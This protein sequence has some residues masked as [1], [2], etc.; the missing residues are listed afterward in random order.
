MKNS[1]RRDSVIDWSIGHWI[2]EG[3][4]RRFMTRIQFTGAESTANEDIAKEMWCQLRWQH[5]MWECVLPAAACL[6]LAYGSNG[7]HYALEGGRRTHAHTTQQVEIGW[8][9]AK[10]AIHTKWNVRFFF[11]FFTS[12][13]KSIDYVVVVIASEEMSKILLCYFLVESNLRF[14]CKILLLK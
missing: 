1:T 8:L 7:T 5:F 13:K 12:E 14:Y 10:T 4:V 2:T 9:N 6:N 11:Y 3:Y